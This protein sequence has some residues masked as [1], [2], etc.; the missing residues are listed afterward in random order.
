RV[1]LLLRAI[2]GA[3]MIMVVSAGTAGLV[4]NSAGGWRA[5]PAA[6]IYLAFNVLLASGARS[7]LER[8]LARRRVRELLVFILFMMW[9]APRFLFLTGKHPDGDSL[10]GITPVFESAVWSW[11]AAAWIALGHSAALAFGSLVGWT[12]VAGWF[13][14]TQFERSLR[15]DMAAAQSTPAAS[16]RPAAR[17]VVDAL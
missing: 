2:A 12:V 9:M 15:F 3:E 7:L 16:S 4:V 5:I 13:G 17:S 11:P 1:E 14:R 10:R 8:L 6:V